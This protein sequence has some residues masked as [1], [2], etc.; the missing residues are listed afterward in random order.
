MAKRGVRPWRLKAHVMRTE[1]ITYV[2]ATLSK[3]SMLA[4]LGCVAGDRNT[5]LE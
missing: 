4:L 2:T 5:D 1:I 3:S